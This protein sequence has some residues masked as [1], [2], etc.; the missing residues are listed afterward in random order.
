MNEPLVKL[1]MQAD[2]YDIYFSVSETTEWLIK[3]SSDIF[4]EVDDYVA[5]SEFYKS[6]VDEH[7]YQGDAAVDYFES[8]TKG[9][10]SE[11]ELVFNPE[12]KMKADYKRL[13]PHLLIF[14]LSYCFD[15][16]KAKNINDENRTLYFMTRAKFYQGMICGILSIP[17]TSLIENMSKKGADARHKDTRAERE[18]VKKYWL[19]KI[20]HSLS[21][22]KAAEE[23]KKRNVVDLSVRKLSE[24][25]SEARKE[26]LALSINTPPTGR[27]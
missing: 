22:D 3:L 2:N 11:D 5:F 20:D 13:T 18:Y 1:S 24:I 12:I 17:P 4:K 26:F 21:N 6:R 25:V 14:A 15:A 7:G 16:L 19:E 27:A 10:I 23:L 9:E 8:I